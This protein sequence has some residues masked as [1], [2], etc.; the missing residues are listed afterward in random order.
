ICAPPEVNVTFQVNMANETVSGDGVHV[1]GSFQSWDPAAS[2]LTLAYDAVYT[3]TT[4]LSIGE[5][6]EYKFINGNAWGSE[7]SVPACCNANSNRY[8]TVPDVD[9]V[10][11][12][13]CF[14]SC[15]DCSAEMVDITFQVDMSTVGPNVTDGVHLVGNFPGNEWNPGSIAMTDAGNDVYTVTQSLPVN[16][17]LEYKFVNGNSWG[18]DESVPGECA[19]GF[20]R[21]MNVPGVNQILDPVCYGSCTGCV[22]GTTDLFISEYAEGS[23]SNKYIELYNG[24]G[25]AVDLSA[26]SMKRANNGS[27]VWQ[28]VLVLEGILADGDV[29]VIANSGAAQYIKDR[30]DI[31]SSIT[32]FNGDDAL[33]LF[34]NDV[35]IDAIGVLGEDPGSNW[36]VAGISPG[37][38]EKTLIR[39]D[40]VCSPN[41]DWASSA[42]TNVDNSEWN[43]E[44]QNYWDD[45][46][47]H[48]AVCG[49]TPIVEKPSLSESQGTYFFP[50]N[51]EITC[52]TA[53]A[54]IYYTTDGS[55]PDMFSTEYT[56]PLPIDLTTTV[57]AKAFAIGFGSSS[58]AAATYTFPEVDEIN[59]I[60]ELRATFGT[61]ADYYMLSEEVVLTF[62]QDYRGQK[63]IQDATAAILIDDDPGIIT[64]TYAR[65]DGITGLIG[66]LTEYGNMLQFVPA[67]DPG[68]ATSSG[69][70]LMPEVITIDEMVTN[71]EDYEAELVQ[72]IGVTFED[73]G[74]NFANGTVYPMTDAS[75]AS[76]DFR[77]TFYDMDYIGTLIPPVACDVIGLPNSRYDGDYLSARDLGDF[78]V[79]PTIVL[80]SPNG[81]EQVEQGTDYDITWDAFSFDGD[82]DIELLNTPKGVVVLAEDVP[83]SDGTFTWMVV[84]DYGD[85]YKIHITSTTLGLEDTSDDYFTIVP[86]IDVVITEIMYNPP[87]AGTDSLEF[88][89]F[90][91][92]GEGILNLLD[93]EITQGV[94]FTFPDH[95]LNPGEYV[96]VCKSASAFLNTFGLDV[97][98]WT[99]GSLGNSGE[100]IELTDNGGI[101]RCY[102]DYDDGGSWYPVTDGEGPSLTFCD[103]DLDNNDPV[104]WAASTKLAAINANGEG[105][106]CTPMAGCNTD[107]V[108]PVWYPSGW[109]GISSNLIPGRIS[110]EDLFA[111]A[112]GNLTIMVSENGIFWPG[113]NI[114]TIGDWN[115]YEGY[116]VKFDGSTYFV[117]PGTELMD[118]TVSLDPGIHFVPVL[119]EGPASVE[120]FIVPLGG[121]IEFMFDI[122][123]G[124][125]Y[126]PAG[127]IVP[128]VNGAL[129][130]LVPGYAYL[131]MVNNPVVIDY[132]LIP[133]KNLP[134]IQY[135]SAENQTTWNNVVNTGRQHIISV[136]AN[137]LE[138][139][140]VIGVFNSDG[141]CAGMSTY[142][143][144]QHAISLVAYG[145]DQYSGQIDGLNQKE[146]LSYKIWRNGEIIEATAVYSQQAP[147]Y[148]G[149]FAE[150]GLSIISELKLGATGLNEKGFGIISIYPNPSNGQFE[151]AAKGKYNLEVTNATGQVIY[152]SEITNTTTINLGDQPKG[153][154]F[155][156]LTSNAI[157]SIQ[158][159][160]IE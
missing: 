114:N 142:D 102:V 47:S 39:K 78:Y 153:L 122:Y 130:V 4:S 50:I 24:T 57:K 71:F 88:I 68:T 103:P 18:Q 27:P 89:E 117:Y 72:L 90:Y 112:L 14:G 105:I 87:E 127:G 150:N 41:T 96:V 64:T 6:Y 20:N 92:N 107:L 37:T 1:A 13:V 146:T 159:I 43:V 110:L 28:D 97:L 19:L 42:G 32:Y 134:V 156:K 80:T 155:V 58:T 121:D 101:Q 66:S 65:W 116:K 133:P 104:N 123:T 38:A 59:T 118:R 54:T 126:W 49:G 113:Q 79:P 137:T 91:N 125:V 53:G 100:D 60:A 143:G 74:D 109:T 108:L 82:I 3:F 23:S 115:T 12:V 2:E 33:G 152:T 154:Y 135:V 45:L 141:M 40:N 8:F 145:D 86:P 76:G 138:K 157:S 128:G 52:A 17:C 56:I 67:V 129:E 61:D 124:E 160:V 94:G 144:S 93:W 11:D 158:K 151:I 36:P 84:Q 16:F 62:Q 73:G 69:N 95:V 75:K 44:P 21:Y 29:Y 140:D 15:F 147:N 51:L 81:G 25:E 148:D 30:S 34:N 5:S 111:P 132:S 131:T 77:T 22:G 136:A 119:S 149:L 9:L 139:G 98:E 85:D 46:G 70:V 31:F 99:S 26:Y 83:V 7:E 10:I 120:D 106:Y 35:F 48:V 55:E 63:Y